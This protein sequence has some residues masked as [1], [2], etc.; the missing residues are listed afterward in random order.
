MITLVT[1]PEFFGSP[2][3]SPFCIKAEYLLNL[4]KLPW[5]RQETNDPRKFP[6]GKLPAIV[7][8]QHVIGDSDNIRTYIEEQ[9]IDLEQGLSA[10]EKGNARA[11]I[12]MTEEHMYFH[13]ALDRWENPE[14]WA[15][16]RD[17]YFAQ[18]PK[19]L[20]GVITSGLRK[21]FLKGM[22][23]Q[24]LGRLTPKERMARLEP[25]LQAISVRLT[26]TP[27]L[28][29]DHPTAAD[30]SVGA[31]LF[32]MRCTPTETLLKQRVH[33]DA[34]LSSYVDRVHAALG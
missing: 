8:G 7:V 13:Q 18:I 4:S 14:T 9:D 24:G 1:F 19:L 12:R 32:A 2:S 31:M 25:D 10:V 33:S 29:G 20:R 21:T 30:A 22:K 23:A 27:F 17:T 3:A 28:F 11:F 5:E 26:Q 16:I 34:I 15:I 6:K